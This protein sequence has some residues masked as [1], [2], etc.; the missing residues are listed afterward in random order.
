M[1]RREHSYLRN[2]HGEPRRSAPR[3][4]RRVSRRLSFKQ[5]EPVGF[6]KRLTPTHPPPPRRHALS[7]PF[8][9]VHITSRKSTRKVKVKAKLQA[10]TQAMGSEKELWERGR[11]AEGPNSM[12]Q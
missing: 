11:G 12:H 6:S 3:L 7:V 1:L 2:Y 8:H 4:S 10:R 5:V 9:W